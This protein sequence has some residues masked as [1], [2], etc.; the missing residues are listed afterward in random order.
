LFTFICSSAGHQ[1]AQQQQQQQQQPHPVWGVAAPAVGSYV[2]LLRL[3]CSEELARLRVW[4]EPMK[5]AEASKAAAAVSV[6]YQA[7]FLIVL[8]TF[9]EGTCPGPCSGRSC[10]CGLTSG[11][12]PF[13]ACG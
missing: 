4:V 8:E 7:G 6:R 1:A 11:L 13:V 12:M 3:L 9:S 10:D 2:A 5:Y